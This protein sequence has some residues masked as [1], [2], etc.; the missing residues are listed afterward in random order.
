M[1]TN[2][3]LSIF[4]AVVQYMWA[5]NTISLYIEMTSSYVYHQTMTDQNKQVGELI[6]HD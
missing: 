3:L 6:C 1:L 2:N 5:G 4:L